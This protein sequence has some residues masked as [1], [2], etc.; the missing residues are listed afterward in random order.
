[1]L[2]A[3]STSNARARTLRLVC[4]CV[5]VWILPIIFRLLMLTSPDHISRFAATLL[6]KKK[7][8]IPALKSRLH[9]FPCALS[10]YVVESLALVVQ[11]RLPSVE[12]A[13]ASVAPAFSRLKNLVISGQNL[14]SNAHWLR[15]HPIHPE[16]MMILHFGHPQ[17]V[18]FKEPI[19]QSVTHLYTSTLAGHRDSSVADLPLLTHLAVHTRI[20]LSE[21]TVICVMKQ[22]ITTLEA[23]PQLQ[24]FVLVLNSIGLRDPKLPYWLNVLKPCFKDERFYLLPHY[25]DV[26]L[27]CQDML[28]SGSEV[29]ERA[30]LWR[31]VESQH[32]T[33][34]TRFMPSSIPRRDSDASR[35]AKNYMDAVWNLDMVPHDNSDNNL[36]LNDHCEAILP[37][38]LI[39]H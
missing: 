27:E 35:R 14:S 36:T 21:S 11:T 8:H 18:N 17:L 28:T 25:R 39:D 1:V 34:E 5:N 10:S 12:T 13:L 2:H 33:T 26:H 15:Q 24:C 16:R 7:L 37:L 31:E 22:L 29:W 32:D 19:F 6:P 20:D 23:T 4:G 9:T 30:R 3:A 38:R